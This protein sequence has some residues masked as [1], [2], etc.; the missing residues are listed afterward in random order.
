VA[1]ER[2][3]EPSAAQERPS[4]APENRSARAGRIL[5]V[6][7]FAALLLGALATLLVVLTRG[8]SGIQTPPQ[9]IDSRTGYRSSDAPP[10]QPPSEPSPPSQP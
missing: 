9:I 6:G 7:T 1:D 5:A 4:Y 3:A 2:N 8:S 10:S